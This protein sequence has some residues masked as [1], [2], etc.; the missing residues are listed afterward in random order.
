M[1]MN[2]ERNHLG[3]LYSAEKLL[4]LSS[5]AFYL[6]RQAETVLLHLTCGE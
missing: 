3:Y 5:R 4:A 6:R 1:S 2:A